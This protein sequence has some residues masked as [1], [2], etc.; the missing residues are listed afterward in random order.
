MKSLKS[1]TPLFCLLLLLF[2]ILLGYERLTTFN[3]AHLLE[4]SSLKDR[5]FN[6]KVEEVF[7]TDK[8]A[9]AYLM[10]DKTLPLVRL[11]FG[12]KHTGSA[13]ETKLGATLLLEELLFTASHTYDRQA[14]ADKKKELGLQLS[15]SPDADDAVFTFSYPKANSKEALAFLKEALFAPTFPPKDLQTAV[16]RLKIARQNQLESPMYALSQAVLKQFYG[17]HPYGREDIPEDAVLDALTPTDLSHR[18]TTILNKSTLNI[19]IAGDLSSAEATALLDSLFSALPTTDDTNS[20]PPLTPEWTAPQTAVTSPFGAQSFVLALAPGVARLDPDFYP[21]YIAN[22][23][24]VG[25]GLTS[26]LNHALREQNGLTYGVSGGFVM[27]DALNTWQIAFS[28]APENLPHAQQLLAEVYQ[29]FYTNGITAAEF[30]KAK[31]NMLNSFNLRFSGLKTIADMLYQ[32]QAQHL[33]RDFLETRQA[34]VQAVTLEQVNTAIKNRLPH[35]F[36]AADG[37]RLFT[38]TPKQEPKAQKEFKESQN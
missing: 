17:T 16:A 21:L 6:G 37:V 3:A 2:A 15:F 31:S 25:S 28:A 26:R 29:D 11:V 22:E 23:V 33:G 4:V 14:F 7:A 8:S 1:F 5:P 35:R 12:F 34:Q 24:L 13:H 9:S 27:Q 19:G 20:L 30:E 36:D 32:M 18:L 10:T 38:S